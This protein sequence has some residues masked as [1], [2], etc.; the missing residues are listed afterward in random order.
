MLL[1]SGDEQGNPAQDCVTTVE[2]GGRFVWLRSLN[3][4]THPHKG[5]GETEG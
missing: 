3:E 5:E 4:R 2:G 1:P